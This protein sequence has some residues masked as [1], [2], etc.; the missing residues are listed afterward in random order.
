MNE[1][2]FI[3]RLGDEID[4]AISRPLPRRMVSRPRW[5]VLA[6]AVALVFLTA[7]A[8]AIAHVL[9]SPDEPATRSIACY[10]RA[11]LS[12]DV[13]V[14]A[15]DRAP[16]AACSD[17]YRRMGQ[18]VPSLVACTNGSSVAV[19]PGGEASVCARLGL[20][21]LPA[22]YTASQ[23]KVARLARAVLALEAS[24]DCIQPSELARRVQQTLD[25]QGWLGWRAA[26]QS[27][28]TGPC[29]SVSGLDG[30]GRRRIDGALD[31]GR[32]IVLVSGSPARSTMALLYGPSG[33]ART[34]EDDSGTRCFT[35]KALT[36][37]V[38]SRA[39][40]V[41][42]SASVELAS[43]LPST[44]TFADAR[45]ARYRAGCAVL[46]EL[47]AAGDGYAIVA[48]VPRPMR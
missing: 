33:L 29:G 2:P 8:I 41:G 31:A 21:P 28:D 6:I 16:V 23:A 26:V 27:T 20:E 37:L 39:A 12:S 22:G 10:A 47:R 11:D 4:A 18:A 1:I 9:S 36:E 14:V 48:V 3:T 35:V 5:G 44:V 45:E 7:A 42:R 38:Q 15:N 19:V 17:A 34:L 43:P 24:Q 25:A 46:T 30:S 40:S 13:T 32:K